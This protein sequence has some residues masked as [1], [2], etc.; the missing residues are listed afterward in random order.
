[1]SLGKCARKGWAW[2]PVKTQLLDFESKDSVGTI[3]CEI[4]A[5][6]SSPFSAEELTQALAL[7]GLVSADTKR[8]HLHIK[9]VESRDLNIRAFTD[10][11]RKVE[12]I[13]FPNAEKAILAV[14]K[15]PSQ[16]QTLR[17]GAKA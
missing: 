3:R 8:I 4:F 16:I 1:M 14:K 7:E 9:G 11:K 17:C 5:S 6:K 12:E 10:L 2:K 15:S 13:G